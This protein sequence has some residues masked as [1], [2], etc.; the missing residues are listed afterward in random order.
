VGISMFTQERR[1]ARS[2][3]GC[4]A[5]TD[6]STP[7]GT[8]VDLRGRGQPQKR[9]RATFIQKLLSDYGNRWRYLRTQKSFRVAPLVTL[10]RLISWRVR[11]LFRWPGTIKLRTWGVRM[12]LPAEWRGIG[13]LVFAF[14]EHYEP[15]LGYLEQVL[16]P[17]KIFAD[18]GACYGIYTLA[19]SKIVG[20]SGRVV[21]FEPSS[22]GFQVLQENLALNGLTN[23]VAYPLALAEKK[24]R[25]S[26]YLHPNIGCDSLGRDATFTDQAEE[27]AT[28]SLDDILQRLSVDHLD[29]LKMDVQGAEELVLRGASRILQSSRPSIIFE[30]F[31]E[32]AET[33]GL[34]GYGAWDHLE[35][36]GYEFF[37]VDQSGSLRKADSPPT[38]NNVVAIHGKQ[39]G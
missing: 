28:D 8:T 24:G 30:I 17:G 15:E 21:A 38:G 35:N 19:A 22:K 4:R 31:P 34:S 20:P 1:E 13:K 5:Q 2:S 14:R 9:A 18:A 16:S 6:L 33:L 36:L 25:A 37:T 7:P 39:G 3:P 27:A 32:G 11:C 10:A 29:V 26:L 12:F 23:V